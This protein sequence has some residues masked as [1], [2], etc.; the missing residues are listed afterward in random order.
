M[1]LCVL[2]FLYPKC[3]ISLSP[4]RRILRED[5]ERG[6]LRHGFTVNPNFI[7]KKQAIVYYILS[8]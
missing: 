4:L 3:G 2:M 5:T 1:F 7:D 6:Y 8:V